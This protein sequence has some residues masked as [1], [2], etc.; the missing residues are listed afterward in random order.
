MTIE[1]ATCD[2]PLGPFSFVEVERVVMA[3]GFGDM[4]RVRS[5]L[6]DEIRGAR[7]SPSTSDVGAR[8]EKY[9]AGDVTA[10][11]GIPVRQEGSPF[12]QKVWEELRRVAPGSPVSYGEMAG[13]IGHPRAARAVGTACA[14]NSVALIVPCHRVTKGGG[15]PGDYGYG[16][17]SKAWL[18]D[19]EKNYS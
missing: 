18:L 10:L 4:K 13:A 12:R 3:A 5:M 17:D 7:V 9:F 1:G 2:T 15:R 19:H 8:I 6:P 16:T 14:T 11:D